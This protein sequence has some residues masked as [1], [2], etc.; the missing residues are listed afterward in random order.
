[1]ASGVAIF[2]FSAAFFFGAGFFFDASLLSAAFWSAAFVGAGFVRASADTQS[3]VFILVYGRYLPP[4]NLS[5]LL[6]ASGTPSSSESS[7]TGPSIAASTLTSALSRC[8]GSTSV[9]E[10]SPRTL[11]CTSSL[12]P[13]CVIRV[14]RSGTR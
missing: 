5:K 7:A 14:T 12:R 10:S 6:P 4:S 1:M 2:F 3:P 8:P 9:T 11:R 13:R